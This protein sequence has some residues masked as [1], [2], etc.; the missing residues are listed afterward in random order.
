MKPKLPLRRPGASRGRS[1]H[2]RALLH[3]ELLEDR[4]LLSRSI[5]S[6]DDSWQFI[7]Q[8]VAGA[9]SVSFDDSAWT[10]VSLPHTWNNLDGQDGGNNYYR[11]TGWYRKHY[12]VATE[13]SGQ[14]LFIKFDGANFSTDL[15]VN[16]TFVGEHRGGFAAF[17]WDLTPYLTIG[18]DNVL[19]VEVSNALDAVE[20]PQS[21]DITWD[22]GLYRHVNL[23]ATDPLHISVTDL[24]SPGIYLQQTNV[25]AAAADLQVTTKLL[26]DSLM[27]RQA[28][29]VANLLDAAGNLVEALT[30]N[31][32]LDAGVGSDVVQSTTLVHPHLWNGRSDPYLYQMSVQVIDSAI[33][34]VV[35]QVEQPLGL[36]TFSIDPNNG[37][38]LN[39]QYL[40]LHGVGFHQDRPNK[41]LAISDADQVEDVSLIN[42][43][44]ANFVRLV[45]YQRP[46]KTYDLLDA[47]GL[48]T[49]TEIPLIDNVVA[50]RGFF[51]G[52]EQQLREMI[53]Q[54][55]NHPAVLFWGMYNEIPDNPTSEHLVEQLV[56]IAHEE[57]PTRPA[58]AATDLANEKPINYLAD[59]VG[60]NKYFGWYYGHSYDFAAWADNIHSAHPTQAIGVSEFGAGASLYQHEDNPGYPH[61]PNHFWHPEEYQELAHE[62]IWMQLKSRPF[63]WVKSVWG[64]FDFASDYRAEGDTLGR[65]DKGLV[66]YDRQT[67]KDA[68]YWY[69]ANWSSDPVLY[70]TS[71]RY[72][73]RPSNVVE[74]KV[75]S[76]LDAVQLSVNGA[77][78]GTQI[79]ADHLFRWTGVVLTPGANTIEVTATQDGFTYTDDVTWYAPRGLDGVS[80]AR[81][82]FQ[83]TGLPVPDDYLPDYGT[84]FG[85]QGNGFSYGWD[86]DN[87]ANTFVRGVMRD[88]RYDTLIAMQLAGG[89]HVWEIAVP[90]GTYD[91]HLVGGDPS[92][93][94]STYE[95]AVEDVLAVS[96]GVNVFNRF[97]EAWRTVTVTDGFLTLSNADG[98]SNNKLNFIEINRI[99]GAGG[100]APAPPSFAGDGN[101]FPPLARSEMHDTGSS[102]AW[103]SNS[104]FV[105]VTFRTLAQVVTGSADYTARE[106]SRSRAESPSWVAWDARSEAWLSIPQAV[107][108]ESKPVL[109]DRTRLW[110]GW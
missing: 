69:K 102:R 67:R 52:A 107:V 28:T 100:N 6:L 51:D 22:G 76:N 74:V 24:A 93:F 62:A 56:Q 97:Q 84:V 8:D 11:G 31:V 92:F 83:P 87:S 85:D 68:F 61:Y 81:I 37:F 86:V 96:G 2:P 33:D 57:D 90:N 89:G 82:N 42:E 26:N 95:I 5:L 54:N 72:L 38:F 103:S 94:D 15:Y 64:M 3:A 80:F 108:D 30:S 48:I 10:A 98:S 4:R 39:G 29:V 109:D 88:L 12:T 59:V 16:G 91:V 43:I 71:R 46:P 23:I 45:M 50:G 25:S 35:D 47:S 21:G 41:G 55:Y 104:S 65:N 40:D 44:G 20:I 53:R 7:R 105:E 77:V 99:D 106:P 17:A 73:N 34:T 70:I 63:L 13:R 75:Y 60:F 36:R 27:P 9:Q 78:L 19:A 18:G 110:L 101:P 1:S 32:T 58:T 49:W 14:E 66:S 79:S